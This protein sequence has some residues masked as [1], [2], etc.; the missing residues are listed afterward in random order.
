M[1]D[2]AGRKATDLVDSTLGIPWTEPIGMFGYVL[3]YV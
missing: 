2:G 1:T 3:M